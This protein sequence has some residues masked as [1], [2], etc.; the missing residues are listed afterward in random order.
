M[1]AIMF[2]FL[3]IV[4][5]ALHFDL[6]ADNPDGAGDHYQIALAQTSLA[7]GPAFPISARVHRSRL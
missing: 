1:V 2:L 6:A 3:I 5:Y 4:T 7:C